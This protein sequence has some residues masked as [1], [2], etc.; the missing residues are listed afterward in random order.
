M[1]KRVDKYVANTG[2]DFE[3][4]KPPIRVEANEAI[5][6]RVGADEI[7]DLLEAGLIREVEE[8]EAAK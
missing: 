1:S 3:Q 7:K 6:A 4:F 2:I 5:P 8:S